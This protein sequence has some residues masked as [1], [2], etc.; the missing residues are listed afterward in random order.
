M[1]EELNV[2]AQKESNAEIPNLPCPN[3]GV[4]F[5][6]EGFYNYCTET[7]SLR[8]DNYTQVVNDRLCIDHD[9]HGHETVDTTN[10][11]WKPAAGTVTKSC[12]RCFTSSEA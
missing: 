2:V 6:T 5:L 12:L 8:E 3:C 10:A 9:E 1:L 11:T 7:A 4:N